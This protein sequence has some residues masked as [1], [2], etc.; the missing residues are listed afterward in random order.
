MHVHVDAC[1]KLMYV[2][3]RD[4]LFGPSPFLWC[5]WWICGNRENRGFNNILTLQPL[6]SLICP[7]TSP[8]CSWC[9]RS[10]KRKKLLCWLDPD[11]LFRDPAFW[12]VILES[13]W[14]FW[15]FEIEVKDVF[16]K[17]NFLYA[18]CFN[19]LFTNN[20]AKK[21]KIRLEKQ[22]YL[23]RN[24]TLRGAIKHGEVIP[25]RGVYWKARKT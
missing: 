20:Q 22:C 12:D 17:K 1:F 23:L 18:W 4:A 6:D 24:L 2:F 16:S 3:M 5:V 10:I 15:R 21:L 19:I 8:Q 14:S 7:W 25:I 9:L 13:L 11:C